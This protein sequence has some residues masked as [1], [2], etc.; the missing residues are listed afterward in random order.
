MASKLKISRIIT[1]VI[2][3]VI[4]GGLAFFKIRSSG[5]DNKKN[6]A[7]QGP[8]TVKVKGYVVKS[9]KIANSILSTGTVYAADEVEIRSE[10][11]GKVT[12]I[13]FKEGTRVSKGQLLVKLFDADLKAELEKLQL[14]EELAST[15]EQRLKELRKIDGISL[16]EYD[17]ALNNLNTLKA[18]I[19]LLEARISKTEIR[20]PFNGNIGLR[21]ISEGA[22]VGPTDP[23]TTLQETNILKIDFSVP[24]KYLHLVRQ[25]AEIRFTI[26]GMEDT[27]TAVVYAIE[28]KID[29][30]T[31]SLMI[32][33]RYDNHKNLLYPGAF[34]NIIMPLREIEDGIMIPTEAVIPEIRGQKVYIARGTNAEAVM[35]EIG[36]RN[37]SLVQIIKGLHPGDTVVTTGLMQIRPNVKLSFTQV[38][39]QN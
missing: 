35:V 4:I 32:R 10:I 39:N 30:N 8:P 26:E 29:L 2:V 24:E 1:W 21:R 20:A 18:D 7:Q 14:Q 36:V 6:Q 37:D 12:G 25:N 23:I 19:K 3:L 13:F 16:Q 5:G 15:T 33:A 17:A 28:P 11:Q 31:R 34:A 22:L 38:R 27:M 9:G